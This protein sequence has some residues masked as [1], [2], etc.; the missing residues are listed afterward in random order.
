MLLSYQCRQGLPLLRP[1]NWLLARQRYKQRLYQSPR[2]MPQTTGG[3]TWNKETSKSKTPAED[4]D[5]D[6]DDMPALQSDSDSES[7]ASK[8]PASKPSSSTASK[9]KPFSL[10]SSTLVEQKGSNSLSST[11]LKQKPVEPAARNIADDDSEEDMPALMSES[12]DDAKPN[13]KQVAKIPEAVQKLKQKPTS[14]L[15]EESV[16]P[17]TLARRNAVPIKLIAKVDLPRVVARPAPTQ[18]EKARAVK[19]VWSWWRRVKARSSPD[20]LR[21]SNRLPRI[22]Y[23]LRQWPGIRRPYL[24]KYLEEALPVYLELSELYIALG[25]LLQGSS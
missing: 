13:M 20:A 19:T 24:N 2:R 22:C 3:P 14:A 15:P 10:S 11:S 25:S 18:A 1:R 21:N 4:S 17:D 16:D 12:S 7:G 5:E 8:R 23:G 9:H 6:F